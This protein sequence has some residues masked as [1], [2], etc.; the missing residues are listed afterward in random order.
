MSLFNPSLRVIM[1]VLLSPNFCVLVL[2]V[3]G[4]TR[5][6]VFFAVGVGVHTIQLAL[7]ITKIIRP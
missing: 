3:A 7:V 6:N 1:S 2:A 5:N 4:P